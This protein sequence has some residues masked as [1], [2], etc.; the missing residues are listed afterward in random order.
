MTL[1]DNFSRRDIQVLFWF[2]QSGQHAAFC[3]GVFVS[4]V[5]CQYLGSIGVVAK[6]F[7]S[8]EFICFTFSM[9]LDIRNV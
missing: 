4:R 5:V 3:N 2:F 1:F 8:H 9:F 7:P 6:P